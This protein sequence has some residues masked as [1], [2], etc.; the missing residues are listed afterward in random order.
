MTNG[1]AIEL[2][3]GYHPGRVSSQGYFSD[4]ASR[5]PSATA[6]ERV[7]SHLSESLSHD[8][9]VRE[10]AEMPLSSHGPASVSI[11]PFVAAPINI[12]TPAT[13]S[14]ALHE[15]TCANLNRPRPAQPQITSNAGS[16]PR[17]RCDWEVAKEQPCGRWIEG[18]S[19]EVWTHVRTTHGLKGRYSGWCHCQWGGCLER[20]KVSS[21]QR[22]LAKHLDIRWRCSS[23]N[24]IFARCDYVRRH[25][26]L[27]KEC[28]GAGILVER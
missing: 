17:Y 9:T 11:L 22:H 25:I 2:G 4:L 12:R 19:K 26:K 8:C 13:P 28:R 6:K 27:S 16:P 15:V 21:L 20:L 1:R 23:C 7:V 5:H 14:V 3:F 10:P 18:G 24:M